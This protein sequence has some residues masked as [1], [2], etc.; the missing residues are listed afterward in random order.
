MRSSRPRRPRAT[1]MRGVPS[2]RATPTAANPLARGRPRG[3]HPS[4]RL[5]RGRGP[6][7]TLLVQVFTR[8]GGSALSIS[9]CTPAEVC[10]VALRDAVHAGK[11]DPVELVAA[12]PVRG[13]AVIALAVLRG[14]LVALE[15]EAACG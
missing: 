6:A 15:V 1:R 13:V 11:R 10:E 14:P 12:Q 3:S 7:S 9:L 2:K 5:R 4:S 8:D